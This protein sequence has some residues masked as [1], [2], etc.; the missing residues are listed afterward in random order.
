MA[1]AMSANLG[2]EANSGEGGGQVC[3][4][5]PEAN[6]YIWLY[7]GQDCNSRGELTTRGG[8]F[9]WGEGTN[10]ILFALWKKWLTIILLNW[11]T[12]FMSSNQT[13]I[14]IFTWQFKVSNPME[15]VITTAAS[16]ITKGFSRSFLGYVCYIFISLSSSINPLYND[17]PRQ[18]ER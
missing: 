1:W 18:N 4:S 11:T 14:W 13:S 9:A 17:Q 15:R 10:K 2:E 3:N 12:H 6:R 7:K 16:Y 5:L 8:A